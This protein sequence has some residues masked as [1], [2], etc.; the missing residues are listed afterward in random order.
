MRSRCYPLGSL[1]GEQGGYLV[2][3]RPMNDVR[4]VSKGAYWILTRRIS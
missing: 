3:G 4:E 1:E 2:V